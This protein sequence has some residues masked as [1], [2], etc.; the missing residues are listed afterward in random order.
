MNDE[1]NTTDYEFLADVKKAYLAYRRELDEYGEAYVRYLRMF[2]LMTEE[3]L[4]TWEPAIY[5]LGKM[6]SPELRALSMLAN[7][8]KICDSWELEVKP[9]DYSPHGLIDPQ[10]IRLVQR[11]MGGVKVILDLRKMIE[12]SGWDK[13]RGSYREGGRRHYYCYTDR[14]DPHIRVSLE[15]PF[16]NAKPVFPCIQMEHYISMTPKLD[17]CASFVLSGETGYKQIP[18]IRH[19]ALCLLDPTL[20]SM[21]ARRRLALAR[22]WN[23]RGES[24]SNR[25]DCVAELFESELARITGNSW[26]EINDEYRVTT[27]HHKLNWGEEAE[28]SEAPLE[29]YFPLIILQKILESEEPYSFEGKWE[30][31]RDSYTLEKKSEKEVAPK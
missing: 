18:E 27:D 13:V 2:G 21:R 25:V 1:N 28:W 30:V 23:H 8:V 7:A 20:E 19:T 17:A 10:E 22:D 29:V 31:N 15:S 4:K 9:L 3:D 11:Y 26:E 16:S 5:N 24:P 14:K 12:E 6:P